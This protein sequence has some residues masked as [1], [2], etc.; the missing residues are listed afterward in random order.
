MTEKKSESPKF[1]QDSPQGVHGGSKT[2]KRF[3]NWNSIGDTGSMIQI[4][5]LESPGLA[6]IPWV[7]WTPVMDAGFPLNGAVNLSV[8]WSISLSERKI[9]VD[10]AGLITRFRPENARNLFPSK[11]R[12]ELENLSNSEL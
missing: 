5:D 6:N 12:E 2:L 4:W 10:A 1:Y 9:H 11:M 3:S 7:P 8:C